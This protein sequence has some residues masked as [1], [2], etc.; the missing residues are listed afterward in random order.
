[1]PSVIGRARYYNG[2]DSES[3]G[4]YT[5]DEVLGDGEPGDVVTV[6][7]AAQVHRARSPMAKEVESTAA[8]T[9]MTTCS[10]EDTVINLEEILEPANTEPGNDEGGANNAHTRRN[11]NAEQRPGNEQ[12]QEEVIP[13]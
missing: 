10:I 1:M 6:I 7:T 9:H 11:I 3:P 12:V 8:P 13:G 4:W 2:L 5:K